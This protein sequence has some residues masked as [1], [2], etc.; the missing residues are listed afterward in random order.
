MPSAT[1][2]T[3]FTSCHSSVHGVPLAWSTVIIVRGASLTMKIWQACG[4][5]FAAQVDVIEMGRILV[6]PEDA[7]VAMRAG[8][9]VR[10][11]HADRQ[12]EIGDLDVLNERDVVWAAISAADTCSRP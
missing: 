12:V 6:A 3:T 8:L 1:R 10:V 9:L 11:L 5:G 4:S 2:R 7:Q